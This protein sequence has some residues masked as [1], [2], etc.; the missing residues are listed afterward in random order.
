MKTHSHANLAELAKIG[1]TAGS[2]TYNGLPIVGST[3][4]I[5]LTYGA[6]LTPNC[7]DGLYRKV[8]MTGAATLNAP[9]NGTDGM[10]WKA[11][12]TASG[13]DRTLTINAAILVPS[14]STFAGSQVIVSGE[15]WIVQLE[16]NGT[17]WMLETLI[18]GWA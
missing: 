2:L 3:A 12:F 10:K 5:A 7:N 11:R 13:A 9:T 17:A 1:E 16:H 14:E 8:T 18:G 6:S 4:P 15:T